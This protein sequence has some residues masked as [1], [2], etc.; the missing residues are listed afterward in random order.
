MSESGPVEEPVEKIGKMDSSVMARAGEVLRHTRES[1]GLTLDEVARQLRLHPTH[2]HA[3]ETGHSVDLPGKVFTIG[4]LRIYAQYLGLTNHE[5]IVEMVDRLVNQQD[6]LSR[7][8]FPPPASNSRSNPGKLLIFLSLLLLFA[9]FIIYEKFY[10]LQP[11][12]HGMSSSTTIGRSDSKPAAV[13]H[14][15]DAGRYSYRPPA[16]SETV[17]IP[18]PDP[19]TSNQNDSNQRDSITIEATAKV[20]IQIR[21]RYNRLI[22][23]AT[24]KS[25]EQYR[26]PEEG[27]PH[28]A[29]LG[30]GAA[31]RVRVG[32][33]DIPLSGKQ[34]EVIRNF[35]LDRKTLLQRLPTSA[36]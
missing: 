5:T 20:W 15:A 35:K 33:T 25:G 7:S 22:Y 24:M 4:F 31:V 13:D 3:L 19:V 21:D 14:P 34:G 28:E 1:K 30:N 23:S 16:D 9:L 2:I 12:D 18:L 17:M 36:R 29:L 26:L 11:V 27:G 8:F 6:R 10:H 32:N